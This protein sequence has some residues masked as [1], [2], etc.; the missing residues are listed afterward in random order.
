MTSKTRKKKLE[1]NI[2]KFYLYRVFS[3]IMFITPIFVLFY[4]ENGLTMTQVMILQ[5]VYTALIMIT[6]VPFGI[7]ADYIGRKKV[8]IAN[9]MLFVLIWILFALSHNFA[10]FLIAEIVAALSSSMWMSSGTAFFYDTLRELNKEGFYS[11][12]A[13]PG[14][15][16]MVGVASGA[17]GTIGTDTYTFVGTCMYG[18]TE[19]DYTESAP[20]AVVLGEVVTLTI[21][22][23]AGI[24]PNS[25]KIYV[26]SIGAT[27]RASSN[28][29]LTITVDPI[30]DEFA[31][32]F[33]DLPRTGETYPGDATGSFTVA[34]SEGTEY[35]VND[36]FTIDISCG[37][38]CFPTDGDIGHGERITITYT[39]RTNPYVSMSIGP[40]ETLPPYVHPVLIAL[41]NDDRA[42]IR[43][44]GV[45]INLWKVLASSGWSWDL[46]TLTFESGFDF[47]WEVLLSEHTLNHGQ[48][49]L[50]NRHLE[51]YDLSN[52]AALTDWANGPG[53]EDVES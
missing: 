13:L 4:Q 53:C 45:E 42:A 26:Y 19:S 43:P 16:T 35:T 41:K 27:T 10:G 3:S 49:E 15:A 47:T 23:P 5:S 20:L 28:L 2:W 44:R 7:I 8:L 30:D 31:V 36:D 32:V 33:D 34:D 6:V 52:L 46:S 48:I 38:I 11:T 18:S 29:V 51:S 14:P 12:D 40:S 9:A 17:G 24:N 39:Y 22:P 21:T 1:A 50:F 25:Y 37:I